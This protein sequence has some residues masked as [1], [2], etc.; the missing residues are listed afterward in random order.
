MASRSN[1]DRDRGFEKLAPR[2][3]FIHK[4]PH[5]A[6]ANAACTG[7]HGANPAQIRRAY[8]REY[9]PDFTE[10]ASLAGGEDLVAV[11]MEA[12]NSAHDDDHGAG[13]WTGADLRASREALGLSMVQLADC[14]GWKQSRISEAERDLRRVPD[15]LPA[16]VAELEAARDRLR[17][18]MVAAL[19]ESADPVLVVHRTDAGYAAAHPT[20]PP[21]PAAVQRV[22]AAL[23]AAELERTMG[24]R[25][26]IVWSD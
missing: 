23:A 6:A 17:A 9:A 12:W 2:L 16:R 15:W 13:R 19:A 4:Q 18:S 1:S 8:I 11:F 3:A 21:L 22:A 24:R 7:Y 26:Q 14:V 25:A 10:R 20:D 5:A